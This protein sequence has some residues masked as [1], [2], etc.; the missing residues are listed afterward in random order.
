MS[1]ATLGGGA[2]GAGGAAGSAAMA[3]HGLGQGLAARERAQE[4]AALAMRY[5]RR[6]AR[7]KYTLMFTLMQPLFW[8]LL[9]GS[10]FSVV[11]PAGVEGSYLEFVLPGILVLNV[12]GA[13]LAAGMEIMF[14]KES[15]FL[16]RLLAC[17]IA[18]TSIVGARLLY[19]IAT[20]LLQ[21]GILLGVAYLMGARLA[22]GLAGLAVILGVSVLLAVALGA[23]SLVLAFVYRSHTEFFATI[24]FVNMP[25]FFLSSALLPVDR[26]PGW[27]QAL[28]ML[29][30]LTHAIDVARA[31]A[32]EGVP[33]D[34]LPGA[35][36]ALLLVDLAALALAVRVFHARWSEP[37]GPPAP[38]GAVAGRGAH[39]L[40][41]P[42][43][44]LCAVRRAPSTAPGSAERPWK[45][46]GLRGPLKSTAGRTAG[47]GQAHPGLLVGSLQACRDKF[48]TTP[49]GVDPVHAFFRLLGW[50]MLV[51]T[52]VGV[53]WP[54]RPD[55]AAAG[56]EPQVDPA[57]AVH[58]VA[59]APVPCTPC[60][61]DAPDHPIARMIGSI[62]QPM[63]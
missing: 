49:Q 60:A 21:V 33:W 25:L 18:R 22:G 42:R 5:F 58:P 12:L 37:A 1:A 15:G 62:V 30:P 34:V 47:A 13:G 51:A 38:R 63:R 44:V 29:N 17:P 59:T 52:L 26:M 35:V 32:L 2:A 28:A 19:V 6:L 11:N 36:G 57:S 55:Q 20:A 4:T 10:L 8:L 24:G 43:A 40:A 23:L 50:S 9:F 54:E 41:R 56:A 45:C 48:L 31:A 39:D 61:R 14:D 16:Q 46:P 7:E 27:M 3:G 53:L